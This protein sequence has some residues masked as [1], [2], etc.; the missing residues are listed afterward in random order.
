MLGI[1]AAMSFLVGC[2]APG[3]VSPVIDAKPVISSQTAVTTP[4]QVNKPSSV[5]G[6][7]PQAVMS[8]LQRARQLQVQGQCD[9]A[10]VVAERGLSLDRRTPELYQLLSLCYFDQGQG[11]SAVEFARQ[12]LRYAP[13]YSE[14]AAR[15]QA[16]IDQVY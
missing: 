16:I 2:G 14:V 11:Q 4:E 13:K 10:I 1:M 5:T 12:G 9:Q 15:L 8:L 3:P 7:P 6:K